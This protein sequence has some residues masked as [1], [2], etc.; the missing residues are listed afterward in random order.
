[1]D[2]TLGMH[3]HQAATELPVNTPELVLSDMVGG[4]VALQILK[5][6]GVK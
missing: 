3:V 5:R 2:H 6:H 1:M 4:L